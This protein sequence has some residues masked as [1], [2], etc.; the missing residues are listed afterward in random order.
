MA[1]TA[2][3]IDPILLENRDN[4]RPAIGRPEIIFA[5]RFGCRIV[6]L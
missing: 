1:K 4:R 5:V 3:L 2:F 6:D